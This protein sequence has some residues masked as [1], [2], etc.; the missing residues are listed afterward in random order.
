[1]ST[2]HCPVEGDRRSWY[3]GESRAQG[4]EEVDGTW[5]VRSAAAVREVLRSRDTVQA[6]FNAEAIQMHGLRKPI[7]FS[8]GEPHRTQR[9]AIA[10]YFAPRVVAERYQELME[11][12]ADELVEQVRREGEVDLSRLALRYSVMVAG[13]VVGL[14]DSDL[15]GMARRLERFFSMPSVPAATRPGTR[16]TLRSRFEALGNGLRGNLPMVPFYLRDVRPAIVAR[17]RRRRDDV[18]SHLLDS[19]YNDAE[20]LVECITYA[21]AGMVT[22]REFISMAAWQLL[23]HHELRERYLA[24]AREERHAILLEVLRL[25]PIVG[26][27]FRRTTAELVLHDEDDVPHVV[28]AGALVDLHVRTANAD[29]AVVGDHPTSLCPARSLPP[30]VGEEVASFG[31]G[32]HRCPGNSLAIQ[33][34]DVL[35]T[36][37]LRLPVSLAGEPTIGWDELIKGYEVRDIRLVVDPAH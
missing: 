23:T 12:F 15:D 5:Q 32:A 25:D 9:S 6:G 21:A 34:T 31:D 30:R 29:P 17:R 26:R 4:V 20:I 19:G 35:L 10:R 1:M 18:I 27:L 7:L 22:T 33:E 36:R 11:R 8:D 13:Q 2:S 24:A 3:P 28:P 16:V 37:L 14:T